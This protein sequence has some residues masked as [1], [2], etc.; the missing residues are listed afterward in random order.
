MECEK[1]INC[2]FKRK[3]K[4]PA[5]SSAVRV[6]NAIP[7]SAG[8]GWLIKMCDKQLMKCVIE[9]LIRQENI[10]EIQQT[11][12]TKNWGK[13]TKWKRTNNNL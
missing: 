13:K 7:L 3:P 4:L 12:D 11:L 8:R 5:G 2:K 1:V 10:K 6:M 9:E